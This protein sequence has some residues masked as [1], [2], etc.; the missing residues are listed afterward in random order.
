MLLA[1]SLAGAGGASSE[2]RVISFQRTGETNARLLVET[3]STRRLPARVC[4]IREI[5]ITYDIA[6]AW[7]RKT[8]K[9]FT[10]EAH[11]EGLTLL[12]KAFES[13]SVTRF[14]VLGSGLGQ[15]PT[16]G[17]C[18]FRSR[19]LAPLEEFNGGR[20]VYSAYKRP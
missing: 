5:I 18:I 20:V 2:V 4:R 12:Q 3:T 6:Q 8:E 17:P 1:A 10:R 9:T 13:H 14:G 15:E 11:L 7:G 16:D 19:G